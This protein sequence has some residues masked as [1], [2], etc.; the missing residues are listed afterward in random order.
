MT[1]HLIVAGCAAL[2]L[3]AGCGGSSGPKSREISR[4]D[5][6]DQWPLTVESGTLHCNGGDGVG[7]VYLTVDGVNYAI[8]G[9]AKGTGRYQDV[10]PIW[11]DDPGTGGLKKGIDHLIDEGLKLCR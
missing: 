7:E 1:K 6:G 4:A 10:T 9:N 5:L 11:A 2:T 8:N 3:L